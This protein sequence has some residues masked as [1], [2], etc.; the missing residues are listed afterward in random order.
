VCI[1]SCPSF[2]LLSFHHTLHYRTR[3]GIDYFMLGGLRGWVVKTSVSYHNPLTSGV[4]WFESYSYR[5]DSVRESLSVDL[6]KVGGLPTYIVYCIWVFSSTTEN[7]PPSYYNWKMYGEEWQFKEQTYFMLC[8]W[9][10]N[11]V[12]L[13][14]QQIISIKSNAKVHFL[15]FF[16]FLKSVLA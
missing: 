4:H 10:I 15:V 7:W 13:I 2:F 3:S 11:F 16:F 14:R 12:N 8:S 1:I 6:W 9:T 5:C